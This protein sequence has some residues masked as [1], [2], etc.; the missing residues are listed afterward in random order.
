MDSVRRDQHVNL[1]ALVDW[2]FIKLHKRQPGE[3]DI[4]VPAIPCSEFRL[5]LMYPDV[6]LDVLDGILYMYRLKDQDTYKIHAR[7]IKIRIR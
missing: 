5:V 4:P 7:Y 6:I 1:V 3:R 2:R